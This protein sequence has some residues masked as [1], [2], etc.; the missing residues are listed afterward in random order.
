MHR[1]G[2]AVLSSFSLLS[3]SQS[4]TCRPRPHLHRFGMIVFDFAFMTFIVFLISKAA[5][6]M[7]EKEKAWEEKEARHRHEKHVHELENAAAR[8]G[9][10]IA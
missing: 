1:H 9:H 2:E 10:H 5:T 6:W 3:L 8:H 7:R 4:F